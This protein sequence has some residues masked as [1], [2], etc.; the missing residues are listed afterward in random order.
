[1]PCKSMYI[2]K[3]QYSA[4]SV[5]KIIHPK[6]RKH[7]EPPQEESHNRVGVGK[8]RERGGGAEFGMLQHSTDLWQG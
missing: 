3:L 7:T 2:F 5:Q 4:S 6:A 8:C 1:M